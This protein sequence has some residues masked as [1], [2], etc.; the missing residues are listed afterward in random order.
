MK[1]YW[2]VLGTLAVWR[3]TH[4]FNAED[5]PFDIFV[6]LRRFAGDGLWGCLLDCFYCLSLWIAIPFA[7]WLGD[8]W[9]E[10]LLLWPALSA[11]SILIERVT[12]PRLWDQ[13]P[14]PALYF[15]NPEVDPNVLLRKEEG[16]AADAKHVH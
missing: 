3:V 8:G 9:K 12:S 7:C 10:R 5:G 4:L 14:R 16:S 1:Y 2:L 6:R 11:A 13:T 15:E